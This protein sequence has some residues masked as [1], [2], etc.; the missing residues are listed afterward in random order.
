MSDVEREAIVARL[1]GAVGRDLGEI[2]VVSVNGDDSFGWGDVEQLR[3]DFPDQSVA[4]A[5]GAVVFSN[6]TSRDVTLILL[7]PASQW[8]VCQVSVGCSGCKR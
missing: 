3:I 2:D 5:S 4:R 8:R 1:D 7:R 6:L